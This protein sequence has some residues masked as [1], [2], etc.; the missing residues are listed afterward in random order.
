[1]NQF[2]FS[3]SGTTILPLLKSHEVHQTVNVEVTKQVQQLDETSKKKHAI[4]INNAAD[5][6]ALSVFEA[7]S[8]PLKKI[9]VK[10][11]TRV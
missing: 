1:M 10:V 3:P 4:R 11:T 9:A 5:M 8:K 2:V 6:R 7:K